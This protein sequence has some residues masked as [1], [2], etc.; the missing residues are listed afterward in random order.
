MRT[1]RC[2]QP[3]DGGF[4]LAELLVSITVLSMILLG[5]ATT[6]NYVSAALV[7][8]MGAA[9]NY[10]KARSTM[11]LIDRDV[12]TMV[13]RRDLA[14]FVGTTGTTSACAFYSNVQSYTG[15]ST[16]MDTRA[17][18]LVDY[19][20]VQGTGSS[21]LQRI[22]YGSNFVSVIP[23]IGATGNLPQLTS[24]STSTETL[25]SGVI[26]FQWQ[27][28]DGTGTVLTPSYTPTGT[29]PSYAPTGTTPFWFDF[30]APGAAYNPRVVVISMAVM[31][32]PAYKLALTSGK[33]AAVISCFPA[34]APS[35]PN[36]TYS[37]AWNAVLN[38]SS[39]SFL[40]LPAP[41]RSGIEVFE[42]RIPLPITTPSS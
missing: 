27:F 30:T 22:S 26:G 1:L 32:Y 6:V 35:S 3:R 33:L 28:V 31:S 17:I 39:T 25:S 19:Q 18:S 4:T 38:S 5:V 24:S 7:N 12:E 37:Q 40:N 15:S 34:T 11:S 14:A 9:D 41:I 21:T 36:Q 29:L 10:E 42:R 13:M 16:T 23:T 20:L 8:G 2:T